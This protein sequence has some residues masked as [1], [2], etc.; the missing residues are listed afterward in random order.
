MKKRI[1]LLTAVV[2]AVSSFGCSGS[3]AD[4]QTGGNLFSGALMNSQGAQVPQGQGQPV[5]ANSSAYTG[6]WNHT[7]E[8]FG[9]QYHT[10]LVI[11]GDGSAA[12]YNDDASLGNF[13]A[14][15]YDTGSGIVISRSDGVQSSAVIENG[16][17]IETTYEDGNYYQAEYTR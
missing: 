3:S 6:T 8:Y 14:S 16:M 1:F 13:S 10:T 2:L 5:P 9:A 11:N 17:L 7:Y 12:Y 4:G 15:W